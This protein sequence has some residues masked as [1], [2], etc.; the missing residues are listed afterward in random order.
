MLININTVNKGKNSV[1]KLRNIISTDV[2]N[3]IVKAMRGKKF[4]YEKPKY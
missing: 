1:F 3:F 4:V 2:A